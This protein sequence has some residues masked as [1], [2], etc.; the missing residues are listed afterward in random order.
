MKKVLLAAFGEGRKLEVPE[1]FQSRERQLEYMWHFKNGL[2]HREILQ[3]KKERENRRAREAGAK[4]RT[5]LEASPATD[6]SVKKKAESERP[7]LC[8]TTCAPKAK[9]MKAGRD[10]EK[11]RRY[12]VMI[13]P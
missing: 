7:L 12:I 2:A 5:I 9:K 10:D 11:V 4:Q 1:R 13:C 8:K 3:Q 6:V